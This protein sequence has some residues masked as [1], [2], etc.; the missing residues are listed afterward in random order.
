METEAAAVQG[1]ARVAVRAQ[2]AEAVEVEV[3][4]VLE[5]KGTEVEAEA[6]TAVTAAVAEVAL[7]ELTPPTKAEVHEAERGARELQETSLVW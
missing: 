5:E 7:Q 2:V 3:A 4:R 6:H 1:A